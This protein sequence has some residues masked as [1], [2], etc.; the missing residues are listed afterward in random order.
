MDRIVID[1]AMFDDY[2]ER[3]APHLSTAFLPF[4][5]ST[6]YAMAFRRADHRRWFEAGL[7]ALKG[8]ATAAAAQRRSCQ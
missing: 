7:Q 5:S 1:E 3:V 6:S 2:L 4:A 8:S